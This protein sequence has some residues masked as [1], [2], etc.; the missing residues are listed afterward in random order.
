M[1]KLTQYIKEHYITGT[2]K[3]SVSK[4]VDKYG[5]DMFAIIEYGYRDIG[6]CSGIEKKE[7]IVNKADFAKL[8]R[9]EGKIV[10]VALYADKRHPNAGSDVYL[11]DRTKNRGR[12]I[13]ANAASGGNSGNHGS[14]TNSRAHEDVNDTVSR[15]SIE[16]QNTACKK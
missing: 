8:Y 3:E 13:V 10:A 2:D 9:N 12:K 6:G 7:D 1:K 5:D 15:H 16:T 4:L 14:Y 11:N